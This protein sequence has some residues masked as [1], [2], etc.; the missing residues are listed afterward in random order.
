MNISVIIFLVINGNPFLAPCWCY[1]QR[2]KCRVFLSNNW[3]TG[4][5]YIWK[6]LILISW[7][8]LATDFDDWT[9]HAIMRW[10]IKVV[11]F[12]WFC[13]K[14]Q[15]IQFRLDGKTTRHFISICAKIQSFF[16]SQICTFYFISSF[17]SPV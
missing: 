13:Q 12:V 10:S 17:W 7:C 15:N 14:L 1:H 5:F 8:H 9:L 2:G 3:K 6:R 16:L 4:V 11:L